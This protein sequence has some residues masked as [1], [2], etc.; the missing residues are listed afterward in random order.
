LGLRESAVVRA[1]DQGDRNFPAAFH[2]HADV[3]PLRKIPQPGRLELSRRDRHAEKSL[4]FGG[5]SAPKKERK[6]EKEKRYFKG[7][8]HEKKLTSRRWKV[9]P[10]GSLQIHPNQGCMGVAARFEIEKRLS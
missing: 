9:N 3:G 4:L 5:M 2:G 10:S 1:V 7:G 8:F 6:K